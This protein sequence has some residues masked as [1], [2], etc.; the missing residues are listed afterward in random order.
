MV[1]KQE[2][3]LKLKNGTSMHFLLYS[4]MQL[5]NMQFLYQITIL[6]SSLP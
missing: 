2:I 3:Q 6:H 5:H 4:C 1:N